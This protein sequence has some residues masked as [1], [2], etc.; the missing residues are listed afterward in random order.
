MAESN[1]SSR[2]TAVPAFAAVCFSMFAAGALVHA[3]LSHAKPKTAAAHAIV[4]EAQT[5]TAFDKADPARTSFGKLEWRGGLVLTSPDSGF[6]GWSALAIDP[7]GKRL[8]SIS[9][10]GVWLTGQ[11]RYDGT[12]PVGIDMARLGPVLGPGG[13]K[14]R[15][16]FD[17]DSEGVTGVSGSLAKG[18]VLISFERNHRIGRFPV[19]ADGLGA[20]TGSMALP[21]E[22]SRMELNRSLE[23]ICRLKA[24]PLKGA[25]VILAE[26]YPS[27]DGHHV[28]WIMGAGAAQWQTLRLTEID[29]FDITDCVGLDDGGMLVLERR[30][31]LQDILE[32]PK[33]RLRRLSG[34]ELASG[35]ASSQPLPGET[36]IEAA[37][38]QEID[39]MEGLAVHRGAAGETVITMISDN[40]FN[41]VL[42]R[43][44]LLQFAMPAPLAT[45]T[46]RR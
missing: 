17:D 46:T 14:L 9:D 18:E 4:V 11:L 3:S 13:S 26:R 35:L 39:N 40:N 41:R 24:G 42:Q 34:E 31:R 38:G 43:T 45:A 12:R 27:S 7:D 20:Q 10:T 16:G 8:L 33:M 5:I 36:L 19:T 6:G 22:A 44:V 15:P 2:A 23:S 30:Y 1:R 37:S 29:G 32:G 28:G 25:T 21:P